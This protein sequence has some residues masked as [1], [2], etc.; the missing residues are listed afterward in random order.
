MSGES[1]ATRSSH[2]AHV[3]SR[4]EP[5]GAELRTLDVVQRTGLTFDF[6]AVS[7]D[8]GS[9]DETLISDGHRVF[10]TRMSVSGL[11]RMVAAFRQRRYRVVHSHLGM[12]SGPVLLAAAL[13]GVPVRIAHFRSDGVGGKRG[14]SKRLMLGLSRQLV[15]TFATRI[16]GV[17]PSALEKGWNPRW[18][19]DSRCQVFPNGI[20]EA[21][22]RRRAEH[23][24]AGRPELKDRLIVVNVG[25]VEP[26]KNRGRAIRIWERIARD[27]PSTLYLVG[28][29][30]AA[31]KKLIESARRTVHSQSEIVEVGDTVDVPLYL[32]GAHAL[33]VTST[34]E[35]L[36]GVV[37]EALA[38]GVPVVGSNLPGTEWIRDHV[39]GVATLSL[40]QPDD[41]WVR[42]VY[43][44]AR[45][46][47][48]RIVSSFDQGPFTLDNVM[49]SFERLWELRDSSSAN[50]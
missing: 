15:D 31:D 44:A 14:A 11:L 1:T 21:S 35:G 33:L 19:S 43:S 41:D 2:V 36:P 24:L 17:A 47:R 28:Q 30:N 49:P 40:N 42:A 39:D 7:G 22:L 6:Y 38:L 37:L 12:A 9:L 27:N 5:A 46:S 8:Q 3:F 32:G 50:E 10:H 48:R 13:A 34:R 45:L 18:P 26:S 23:G 29:V 16:I 25:R 20:D 4:M